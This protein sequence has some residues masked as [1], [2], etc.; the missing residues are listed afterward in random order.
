MTATDTSR[1]VLVS[2]ST[3]DREWAQRF[4]EALRLHRI[5][6]LTNELDFTRG[7]RVSPVLETG[8]RTADDIVFLVSGDFA[9]QPW[10]FFEF[11]VAVAGG[12]RFVP[13]VPEDLDLSS[14]PVP[15][16]SRRYFVRRSPEQTAADLYDVAGAVTRSA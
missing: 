15:M 6:V 9:S 14:F 5:E 4:A 2:F 1:K 11:G 3:A 7:D 12:K 8:L 16:Q 10:M 13:I